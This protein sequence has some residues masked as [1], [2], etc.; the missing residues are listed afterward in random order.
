[1]NDR[2]INV[3]NRQIR[4]RNRHLRIPELRDQRRRVDFIRTIG[5]KKKGADFKHLRMDIVR[6]RL[7]CVV[8]IGLL[9]AYA[10]SVLQV[11]MKQRSRYEHIELQSATTINPIEN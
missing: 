5:E 6:L 1:M 9:L 8:R 11:Y 7:L 4:R 3:E 2:V 10:C